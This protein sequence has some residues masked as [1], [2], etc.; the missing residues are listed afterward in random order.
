M[1]IKVWIQD[2]LNGKV[3]EDLGTCVCDSPVRAIQM[4]DANAEVWFDRGYNADVY[5]SIIKD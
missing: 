3:L 5:Y 2:E 1:E 4:Y